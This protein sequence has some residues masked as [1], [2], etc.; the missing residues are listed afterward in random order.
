M[1]LG[2][3][4]LYPSLWPIALVLLGGYLI[5]NK[6]NIVNTDK[7][8]ENS[9]STSGYSESSKIEDIAIFGGGHKS[10]LISN[11]MGGRAVA[12]FG[13]SE[14]DLR[15]CK[16]SDSGCTIEVISIFGGNSFQ[17]PANWSVNND[18]V[19]IFGGFADSRVKSPA[20]EYD[21]SQTI[22]FKGIVL[23]GGGELK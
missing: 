12:I 23:F 14:I 17:V 19:S 21:S 9:F 8:P 18:I 4:F 1:F 20:I 16:I 13:G 15:G 3:I 11:F 5:L 22:H 7:F 10:Y 2:I 6:K